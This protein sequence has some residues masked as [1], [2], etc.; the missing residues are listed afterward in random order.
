MRFARIL[1][2]VLVPG[3]AQ[4]GTGGPVDGGVETRADF[5]I[6]D[7]AQPDFLAFSGLFYP[8]SHYNSGAKPEAVALADFDGDG[9]LDVVVACMNALL[10]VLHGDSTPFANWNGGRPLVV[11]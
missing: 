9:K 11:Q 1:L 7:L 8:A 6:A 2:A 4:P 10:Y 3:C 5:T